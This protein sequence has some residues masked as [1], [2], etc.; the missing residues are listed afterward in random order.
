[1]SKAKQPSGLIKRSLG[2]QITLI[3]IGIS[4]LTLGTSIIAG[5]RFDS[6]DMQNAMEETAL[7]ESGLLRIIV[8][9]PMLVGDDEGTTEVF[10]FL[11]KEFSTTDISIAGFN[12]NITYSTNSADIRKDI[13]QSMAGAMSA[14]DRAVFEQR[15]KEALGG[16]SP[17]GALLQVNGKSKFLHV[18]PILNGPDCY[19]CH[20]KSQPVLGAMAVMMDVDGEVAAARN[21]TVRNSLTS[22]AGGILLVLGIYLFIRRRVIKRLGELESTS[23]SILEGDFNARF[24][25]TGED[26]LGRVS[27]NLGD[28]LQS[29]KQL[30]VDQSVVRGMSVP[31]VLCDTAGRITFINQTL[32][33]L[34]EEQRSREELAGTSVDVLIYSTDKPAESIFSKVMEQRAPASCEAA[35]KSSTGKA[36]QL[37][38]DANPV[39]DLEGNLIG[40]FSS[41]MDLTAI[42]AHEAA[43]TAQTATIKR[44]AEEAGV[45]TEEIGHAANALG[46]QVETTRRRTT[47]QQTLSDHTVDELE[48]INQAMGNVAQTASHVALHAGETKESAAQGARQAEIVADSM[49]NMSAAILRLKEQMEELGVKTEGIGQVMQVIQDI[50]DQTNLL[51]LNAAIEAARAGDAG[52]GFAVVA[53]EV[54]KLAEKT[55]QATVEVGRTVNEIRESASGSI[56]AVDTTTGIVTESSRQV[57]LAEQA[58]E[59]ILSLAESV[60]GEVEAIA[61]ATEQ[62]SRSIEVVRDSIRSIKDISEDSATATLETESAVRSLIDIADSLNS[63]VAGM[64][65]KEDK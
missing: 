1:M 46:E 38:F 37:R 8:D 35:V 24:T 61:A 21:R 20:G 14:R 64:T 34:L 23:N 50:A 42:R 39:T 6:A 36:L 52:R 13:T 49:K 17:N 63:I 65:A 55:M 30:G 29:L 51:A 22:I 15:Y 53:D 2:L 3:I 60:A 47:E 56:Q 57:L 31:S 9:K 62:Q 7:H 4:I 25:V 26:E 32:L 18:S 54:R 45:L 12:S 16:K 11:S 44:T 59:H 27:H 10:S 58:L 28:M 40:A 33:D 41:I 19:H 43:V 5:L 48:E